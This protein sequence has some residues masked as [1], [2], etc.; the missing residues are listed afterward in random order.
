MICMYNSQK[1]SRAPHFQ[2][3][4]GISQ[5]VLSVIFLRNKSV[6][7]TIQQPLGLDFYACE[8]LIR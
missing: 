2:G 6:A 5:K 8:T 4:Q 7:I 1:I 3:Y